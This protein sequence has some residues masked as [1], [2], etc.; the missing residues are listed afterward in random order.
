[1]GYSNKF[2]YLGQYFVTNAYAVSNGI[3]TVATNKLGVVSP[4]G[5]LFPMQAGQTALITMPD[6]DSEYAQGTGVVDVIS[7]NVDANHDGTMDFTYNSPDFVSPSHPF[8][9]W[10]NDNQD[11][12]DFG[13]DFGVPGQIAP[14]ADGYNYQEVDGNLQPLY[15]VHGVR[16]LVDYFPIYLN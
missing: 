10:V 6:P 4:Y 5:Y 9:F 15:R 16:D 7:L 13:G 8:R 12:G 2:A 11:A 3:V 1:N 14:T